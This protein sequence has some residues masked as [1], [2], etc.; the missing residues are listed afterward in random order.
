MRDTYDVSFERSIVRQ[1]RLSGDLR[2]TP[3]RFHIPVP[4]L[5]HLD[6]IRGFAESFLAAGKHP[7]DFLAPG[8]SYITPLESFVGMDITRENMMA[9]RAIIDLVTDAAMSTEP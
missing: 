4:P 5:K 7:R 3:G 6:D 9:V 2:N 8:S 1:I